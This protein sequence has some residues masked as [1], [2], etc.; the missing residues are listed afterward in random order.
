MCLAPA[1]LKGWQMGSV[2]P[3]NLIP[4]QLCPL[5]CHLDAIKDIHSSSG[6]E[7]GSA[8]LVPEHLGFSRGQGCLLLPSWLAAVSPPEPSYGWGAVPGAECRAPCTL[9]KCSPTALKLRTVFSII[10]PKP[11]SPVPSLHHSGLAAPA[12][13]ATQTPA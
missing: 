5:V 4:K 9:S 13:R 2:I 6:A 11:M 8:N 10:H 3:P 7:D 12:P 1:S